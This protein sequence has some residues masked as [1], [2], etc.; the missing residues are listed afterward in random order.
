[1]A[2]LYVTFDKEFFESNKKKFKQEWNEIVGE[3]IGYIIQGEASIE[4]V[5]VEEALGEAPVI[6]ASMEYPSGSVSGVYVSVDIPITTDLMIDIIKLATKQLNK[7]KT[8]LE[9]LK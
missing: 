2:W 6:K 9:A 8:V 4:E 7:L 1:M 5:G 3:G